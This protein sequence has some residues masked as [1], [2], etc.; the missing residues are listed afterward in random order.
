MGDWCTV[1]VQWGLRVKPFNPR[2]DKSQRFRGRLLA[3]PHIQSTINPNPSPLIY[4]E[5]L[6]Q[7]D[8]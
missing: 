6:I 4:P 8:T 1:S 2:V 3:W 7:C 5:H